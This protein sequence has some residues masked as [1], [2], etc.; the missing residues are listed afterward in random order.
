MK[1][2]VGVLGGLGHRATM[3]A[4]EKL[5]KLYQLKY[6]LEHTCPIRLLSIDFKEINS[7][8]PNGIEEASELLKPFIQE[9]HNLDVVATIMINNT[10]HEA[11]DLIEEDL[12]GKKP[13]GHIGLLVREQVTKKGANRVLLIGTKHTMNSDYFRQ[14]LGS[15]ID[16]VIPDQPLQRK[17]EMLR[18]VYFNSHDE[19]LANE[20]FS[21]LKKI[22]VDVVVVAC[23]ELSLAFEILF[24]DHWI[25]TMDLQCQ[26]AIDHLE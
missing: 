3:L 23:T 19:I 22:E 20:C 10:L 11:Y 1:K 4:Y 21:E 2:Y 13:F 15:T 17:L 8:L 9:V 18:K 5:N 26:F 7:F 6:G 16:V 24:E 25:D 14:S 12:I